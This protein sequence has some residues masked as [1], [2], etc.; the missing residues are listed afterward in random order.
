[1]LFVRGF[2]QINLWFSRYSSLS[3]MRLVTLSAPA[4]LTACRFSLHYLNKTSCLILRI[5]LMI[6]DSNLS[7]MKKKILLTCVQGNY[8][9]FR[10]IQQY[11]ICVFAE[12]IKGQEN[13]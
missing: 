1:M 3:E 12:R 13:H 8:R 6:I 9:L 11:I 4:S 7:K 10:R 5:K 2:Q